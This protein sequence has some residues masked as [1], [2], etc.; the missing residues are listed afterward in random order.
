MDSDRWQRLETLFFAALELNASEKQA[1]LN[2]AC[3]DDFELR[4]ELES[5]LSAD[6]ESMALA[7]ESRL[8]SDEGQEGY[9]PNDLIG[10][11]IGSY[12]LEKLI[13]EGGMG[14]VYLAQRDDD[15]FDQKV[16]L[17]LVRPGYRS[18]Q[19]LARFRMERQ[20]LA[21]LS[22]PN[23][24]QLL[25]G[26][27]DKEGRPYLVMQYVDGIPITEFCDKHALSIDERLT[28]FR[29]VCGAV[30]H[31][32]RN[33]VVH[34]DLKPSNI[35][36]TEEG[37]VKL[38][39]FGIAKLL[40]PDW[41]FSIAV[42]R[43]QVRLMTPEYAAPEQ[44]KGEAITT[45]TDVYA[46]G[47]LL[48]E[49]LSGRR[50]YRL[51]SR[52]Q[53]EIERVICEEDPVRP[54]TAVTEPIERDK[55]PSTPE[56]VSK[57]RRTG[58]GRL[59]K[60]LQ[61]D[62]D[63][64]VM[65]ALRKEPERRYLSVEQFTQD[66]HRYLEQKPL[67]ARPNTFGY[68]LRKYVKRHRMG[69]AAA[70]FIVLSLIS[71]LGMTLHQSRETRIERDRAEQA[72]EQSEAVT[73]FLMGLFKASDLEEAGA[74]SLSAQDLLERGVARAYEL[75]G[76]PRVYAR[77]LDVIGLSFL[78]LGR[79]Q[80]AQPLLEQSLDTWKEL[81]DP[82][83]T[84]AVARHMA[85]L[86][87]EQQDLKQGEQWLN[88]S[89]SMLE[90]TRDI[91]PA[92]RAEILHMTANYDL[93]RGEF[94]HADSIFREVV[95]LREALFG[96]DDLRTLRSV[97]GWAQARYNLNQDAES[98]ALYRRALAGYEA[99]Y[100]EV[101]IEVARLKDYLSTLLYR[102]DEF[103]KALQLSSESVALSRKIYPADHPSLGI[104]LVNHAKL[105]MSRELRDEAEPLLVEAATLFK[106]AF[107]ASHP[108]YAW[109]LQNWATILM[110]QQKYAEAEA[111]LEEIVDIHRESLG[112]DHPR[113]GTTL[114]SY[115]GLLG[116]KGEYDQ[117][118][119]VELEALRIYQEA[120]GPNHISSATAYSLLANHAVHAKA[121][122]RALEYA[123][124]SLAM[125]DVL[126]PDGHVRI[127]TPLSLKATIFI[128]TGKAA[129]AEPLL[130]KAL[131]IR[132]AAFGADHWRVGQVRA[133]LGR[134]LL[135]LNELEE[136]RRELQ[137]AFNI[138]ERDDRWNN[139]MKKIVRQLV[140]YHR[141]VPQPDSVQ[142]YEA[143]L[144]RRFPALDTFSGRNVK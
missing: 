45:A 59:K 119:E 117:A 144:N 2:E 26:G 3:G 91:S 140:R 15:H 25:D 21:R 6:E 16:A 30:Q 4:Q 142:V 84:A 138:H 78:S 133:E 65:M 63:N 100:G 83:Q 60:M 108:D 106:N 90:Y 44:V 109:A 102:R 131:S 127:A 52:M 124:K 62:L 18:S 13:G 104:R 137:S 70:F 128:D 116:L 93:D 88:E 139:T 115:S 69:I 114:H 56:A 48:Y 42:T 125:Y 41:D 85:R 105:L 68:R 24:T 126:Y 97:R 82:V 35:L 75:K 57:A 87:F 19:M 73:A 51:E 39:D 86:W 33:L 9:N 76:E 143:L 58:I 14:E 53:A 5:M 54:S 12:R 95:A 27:I 66:I 103:E 36:V 135:D 123:E 8:L 113:L 22:H 17:K 50:P 40:D 71:G 29:T 7:L 111:I 122:E 107:G 28:L 32:H 132:S 81:D 89:V 96:P 20:V 141:E 98:E 38:L 74:D 47:V 10:S 64:I 1:F 136:A 112:P 49:I 130:R 77:M 43:S 134:C 31:A 121:F 120:F 101:H 46:L 23:I 11:H 37:V 118:E 79:Y 110:G 129:E 61:G 92:E 80:K 72:L 67:I 99:Q 94:T 55:T 34:R